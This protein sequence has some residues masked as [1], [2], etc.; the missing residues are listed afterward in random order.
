MTW[1]PLLLADPSPNLRLLVLREL[2][3]RPAGDPEV[4]ELEALR[5][6]DPLVR[7]LLAVQ[8]RDGSWP[9]HDGGGE[10]WRGIRATAQALVRLGYLGF[11]PELSALRRA[12]EFAERVAAPHG[13]AAVRV[14]ALREMALGVLEESVAASVA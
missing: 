2:L 9:M 6:H 4:L 13:L 8:D 5:E 11:G 14:P 12:A 3:A 7:D 10:A 1:A